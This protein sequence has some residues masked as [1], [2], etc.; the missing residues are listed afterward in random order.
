MN[1]VHPLRASPLFTDPRTALLWLLARLWLGYNWL[2]SGI[3][4]FGD[5]A[6]VGADAGKA[7]RMFFDKAIA[8]S[9]GQDATVTGWYAAVL[10]EVARPSAGVLTYL[11]PL[12]EVTVGTLLILGLLSTL[13]ALVGALLNLNFLLAGTLG[14]NPLML[15]LSLLIVAAPVAGWW[16][17][18]GWLRTRRNRPPML[19]SAA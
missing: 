18:D 13:A 15:A 2:M 3:E 5:P 14:L 6:W 8:S 16:G 17:L 12:A 1:P 19:E 9:Q 4:K 7:I 11:I 10:R